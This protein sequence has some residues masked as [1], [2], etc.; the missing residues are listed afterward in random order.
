[1]GQLPG[2][3]RLPGPGSTGGRAVVVNWARP[4]LAD[5]GHGS[6]STTILLVVV[7]EYCQTHS[8]A[9][10]LSQTSPWHCRAAE[11]DSRTDMRVRAAVTIP[12]P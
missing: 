8:E 12:R 10:S 4:G 9:Q 11:S 7:T 2:P 6:I 5:D 3:G 1:M